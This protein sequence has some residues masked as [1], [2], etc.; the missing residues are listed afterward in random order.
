MAIAIAAAS[1]ITLVCSIGFYSDQTFDEK[2]RNK[3][4]TLAGFLGLWVLWSTLIPYNNE[5]L[6]K[7]KIFDVNGTQC[8]SSSTSF[9][10]RVIV[11]LNS[12]FYKVINEEKEEVVL[13]YN[14]GGWYKGIYWMDNYD[15]K[16]V[17]KTKKE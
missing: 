6:I 9:P 15:L 2:Q 12:N 16:L 1:I 13:I 3:G 14:E 7:L 8:S 17:E 10:S 11:N 5:T 4:L